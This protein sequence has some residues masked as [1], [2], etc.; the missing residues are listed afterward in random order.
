MQ[1]KHHPSEDFLSDFASGRLDEGQA[2]AVATHIETCA[3]CRSTVRALEQAAGEALDAIAPVPLA[4]GALDRTLRR[5]DAAP[6]TRKVDEADA[7]PW[8]PLPA[9]RYKRGRWIWVAP[10]VSMQPIL[11][12]KVSKTRA[13]LLKSASGTSM[14]EHTHSGIEMTCVLTGSFTH[15][16][17]RFRPGDFDFG[18]DSVDH[19]PI[20]GSDEEC[21]CLV[22][23][24]GELKL[25]GL[26]GRIMQ[27]FIRL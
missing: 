17:G 22:A 16:G 27:P 8:L 5:L 4:A 3:L 21:I 24:T 19:Q 23:M 20:V 26:L 11:L 10:G 12:P 2:L 13:F 25:K 14:L 6:P 15:V 18:D 1:A 9:R 7:D